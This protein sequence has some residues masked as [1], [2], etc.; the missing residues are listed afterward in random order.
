M[1]P[2]LIG[3]PF[4]SG[5]QQVS[6]PI[7][8]IEPSPKWRLMKD[9]TPPPPLQ[10]KNKQKKLRNSFEFHVSC[11]AVF[12]SILP[13]TLPLGPNPPTAGSQPFSWGGR[14]PQNSHSEVDLNYPSRAT[15]PFHGI[16]SFKQDKIFCVSC[17]F[18]FSTG[19]NFT[20]D[21][22]T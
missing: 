17:L 20:P 1:F 4:N 15:N 9:R 19:G 16:V 11:F 13:L 3:R 5:Y 7:N 6:Q 21:W 18:F 22:V 12:D 2:T 10:K 8:E 14:Y